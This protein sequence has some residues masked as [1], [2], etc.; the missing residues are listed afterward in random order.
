M[1]KVYATVSQL[2][3]S[4]DTVKVVSLIGIWN[5]VKKEK[6]TKKGFRQNVR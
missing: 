5:N 1:I 3:Y 2:T 6:K 4:F